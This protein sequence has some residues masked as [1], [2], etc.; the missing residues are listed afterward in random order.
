[1]AFAVGR[2]W[3]RLY[4]RGMGGDWSTIRRNS[5]PREVGA[6]GAAEQKKTTLPR[7]IAAGPNPYLNV[8]VVCLCVRRREINLCN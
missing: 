7:R 6:I 4:V 8:V 2:G 1:M 3:Q 5:L